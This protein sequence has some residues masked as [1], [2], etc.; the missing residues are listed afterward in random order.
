[1]SSLT[2]R[3]RQRIT[4]Q[5]LVVEQDSESGEVTNVWDTVYSAVPAEVLT[6]AG[7]EFRESGAIQAETTA[8]ITVRWFDVDR[9]AIY[10]WRILWDGRVYNI[11]SAETDI[12]GRK[13]WRFRCTDGLNDGA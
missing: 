12:T 6:G 2:G 13:E 9:V 4:L 5:A 10:K 8:R 7:R 1:V 3:L 11:V